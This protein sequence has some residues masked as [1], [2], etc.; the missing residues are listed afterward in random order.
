MGEEGPQR[1]PLDLLVEWSVQDSFETFREAMSG[2]MLFSEKRQIRKY[3]LA[4]AVARR[5]ADGLFAEFGVWRG[6]G[7]NLFA[8]Q[9]PD[10]I[11]WGFDSFEGLEEDWTGHAKGGQ[12]GRFTLRGQ[13]PEVAANVRLVKG[14][15]Q[16]TV[17][18]WLADQ[19]SAP[20]LFA[21]LDLDTYTPT[22]FVLEALRPRLVRG[23]VLLFD[24]LYGYPGWRHHEWKALQEVLPDGAYRFLA[25]SEQAVGI[26]ILKDKGE[27]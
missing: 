18:G 20:I 17:P 4:Q 8:K 10:A 26:E 9:L 2:A 24:E 16:D 14:W 6:H 15:V 23:T 21:H 11:I 5:G 12:A 27:T 25:F 22:R 3:C 13:L 1:S 7:V 19:G